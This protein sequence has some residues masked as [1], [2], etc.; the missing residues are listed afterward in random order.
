[1]AVLYV[2]RYLCILGSV[3]FFV[4]IMLFSRLL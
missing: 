3:F 1:M 2:V 4:K